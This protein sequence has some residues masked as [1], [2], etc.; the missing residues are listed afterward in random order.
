[1][2][3]TVSQYM[4]GTEKIFVNRPSINTDVFK[5]KENY[6]NGHFELVILSIGRFTFQKGYLQG[7]LAMQALR[8]R[9][10]PIRWKIV[11][12]GPQKEEI[13]YHIHTLGLHDCVELLG[14]K[15]RDEILQLYNEVDV[16]LLPS[17]YE[18]IANVCLEAMAM[19][20]PVVATKSG[21][22]EEVIVHGKNGLLCEIYSPA[23]IEEQ[24][25]VVANDFEKRNELGIQARKTVVENFTIQKQA[26][27]FEAQYYRL[28]NKHS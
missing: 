16:F 5:R 4:N 8:K 7:L 13:M 11:G 10:L 28:V 18:G 22:M 9:G 14:K 25:L 17:I 6:R 20:L 24:L 15:N 23:S 27:I 3:E 12:D 19:E 21:G 2:A 1:M 26:D